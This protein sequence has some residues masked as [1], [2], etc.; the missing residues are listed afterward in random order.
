MSNY[1]SFIQEC[2]LSQSHL[3]AAAPS[4]VMHINEAAKG[5]LSWAS[6]RFLVE[7]ANNFHIAIELAVGGNS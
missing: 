1:K 5:H 3:A 2:K 6:L 7:L 4:K